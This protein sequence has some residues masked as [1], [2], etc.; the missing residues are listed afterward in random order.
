MKAK[1]LNRVVSSPVE[2][3]E[4]TKSLSSLQGPF[5]ISSH[6]ENKDE[7]K[8]SK[9][10]LFRPKHASTPSRLDI[11]KVGVSYPSDGKGRSEKFS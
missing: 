4:G 11:V 2:Q 1:E 5:G 10:K 6:P 8:K 9:G 7:K 3:I